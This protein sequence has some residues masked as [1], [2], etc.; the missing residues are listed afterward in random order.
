MGRHQPG[1][2]DACPRFAG[3]CT[4]LL[5]EPLDG[6][7]WPKYVSFPVLWAVAGVGTAWLSQQVYIHLSGNDPALFGSAFSS[8]L[9]WSRLWPNATFSLGIIFAICWFACLALFLLWGLRHNGSKPQLHWLR[10]LGLAAILL[11]FLGG[12]ILVSLKIGGGGD[13]HNLDAFLVFWALI[14]G[15]AITGAYAGQTQI[16]VSP[17]NIES[18]GW[19][20]A[21]VVPVFF[22]VMSAHLGFYF[23]RGTDA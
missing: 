20:L 6:K 13:L 14:A 7:P 8:E 4:Y 15:E 12:G 21:M 10:W 18:F 1:Q 23:A 22:V 3:G 2:L 9:L 11:A 19:I 16:V 17:L 5:D